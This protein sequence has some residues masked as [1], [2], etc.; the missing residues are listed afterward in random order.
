MLP[1]G[2]VLSSG[3]VDPLL[4]TGGGQPFGR[5]L[6]EMV[7]WLG[8]SLGVAEVQ[9]GQLRDFHQEGGVLLAPAGGGGVADKLE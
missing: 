4:P 8:G 2:D 3:F 1:E 7:F 6:Q 5:N 9:A